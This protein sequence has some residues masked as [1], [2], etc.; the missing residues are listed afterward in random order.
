M[1]WI[2]EHVSKDVADY[3]FNIK[4]NALPQRIGLVQRDVRPD[5]S[6]DYELM[7]EELAETPEMLA[8]WDLLLVEQSTKVASLKRQ[9]IVKRSSVAQRIIEAGNIGGYD[10][11]RSDLED[12]VEADDGVIDLDAQLIMEQRIEGRLK[13]VVNS[14]KVKSEHLR[15]LAGFKRTERHETR[16]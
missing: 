2:E 1:G 14:I 7:E 12:L 5:V 6:I 11:R 15:S 10:T 13:V 9:G 16:S 4:I 8:F 3:L